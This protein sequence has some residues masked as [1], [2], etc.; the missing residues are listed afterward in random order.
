MFFIKNEC[1]NDQAYLKKELTSITIK[2]NS[3]VIINSSVC[4]TSH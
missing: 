1:D 4:C 3:R 2:I